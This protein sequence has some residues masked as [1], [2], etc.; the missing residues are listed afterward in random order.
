LDVDDW[1]NVL[2]PTS[3]VRS[4]TNQFQ[5]EQW[6]QNC[7]GPKLAQRKMMSN[8]DIRRALWVVFVGGLRS[9]VAHS[10]PHVPV[11][12]GIGMGVDK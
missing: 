3:V 9:F 8:P 6:L 2:P 7:L 4:M 12:S 1:T 11:V 10:S 5:V